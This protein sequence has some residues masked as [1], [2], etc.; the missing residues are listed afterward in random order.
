MAAGVTFIRNEAHALLEIWF[1]IRDAVEGDP[2]IKGEFGIRAHY[3]LTSLL[4]RHQ[5]RK[6]LPQPN[7]LDTSEENQERYKQYVKRAVFYNF[8]SR[9]RDGLVGQV[10]LRPPVS[11][12]PTE[13]DMLTANADGEGLSLEQVSKRAAQNVLSY[14][15]GGLLTD[16]PPTDGASTPDELKKGNIRPVIKSYMP[17]QIR[18]WATI[19]RGANRVLSLIVLEEVHLQEIGDFALQE[20]LTYRVLRLDPVT[21]VYTVELHTEQ[22]TKGGK[23]TGKFDVD[24]FTPTDKD[25]KTF[26]EIPFVPLGAEANDVI[27]DKPPLLDLALL[28]IA[29]YR[30]SADYEEASFLT[31]QPTCVIIGVTE[32]W[33]TNVL[34]GAVTLGSRASISLPVGADAKLIQATANTMPFEAMKLK[35]EQALSLGAKLVQAT[36][37]VRTAT[38]V[39]VDTT[40]ESSV[41][42]NVAKNVSAGIEQCL[43]WAC[44]FVGAADTAIKYQLN[45]EFELTRMNANDRLAIVKMWQSG[46][47]AFTEMRDVL[48]VDGTAQL[49]D[50]TA[51]EQIAQEQAAA[52]ILGG[53]PI[54]DPL[55]ASVPTA[56]ANIPAPVVPPANPKPGGVKK[57][58][59]KPA[60]AA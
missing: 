39:M 47:I 3:Y 33:V 36:K 13:L 5:S 34:K 23:G 58:T 28:N 24:R 37:K 27:P 49:D 4:Y 43:K 45:T 12:I 42:H 1:L 56:P 29:H 57:K 6:Y 18:N 51:S 16:F 22:R 15:R 9:T 48:R 54:A 7:P 11:E 55:Q 21:Y 25:G 8:T 59:K 31:G 14:G 41:L 32:Q 10:F 2:A 26:D 35:E 60:A 50:D 53:A 38:E 17:W 30:N 40:S 20:Q 46:A 19:Q 44:R 52:A